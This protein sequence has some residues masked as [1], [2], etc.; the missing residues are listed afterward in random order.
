MSDGR[1]LFKVIT[2]AVVRSQR[3]LIG[4]LKPSSKDTS[5]GRQI[6]SD[7]WFRELFGFQ[8]SSCARDPARV[9][10]KFNFD[11]KTGDL[12][13]LSNDQTFNAGFFSTPSLTE[14]REAAR[15]I[16]LLRANGKARA[17]LNGRDKLQIRHVATKDVFELHAQKEFEGATF[18]AASQFNCLE[19]PGPSVVPED[20]INDYVYDGTQGPACALAAP[21]GTVV[22]N[23]FAPTN[24][25]VGQTEENQVRKQQISRTACFVFV[26]SNKCRC[27]FVLDQQS[28]GLANFSSAPRQFHR[29]G[30]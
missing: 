30:D 29:T 18:M 26:L 22:R 24:G 27:L 20:G 25:S 16:G 6:N 28:G 15:K 5:K 19:F 7:D 1:T 14:L 2:K 21:A 11:R 10:S 9:R 12:R 13:S 17:T 3:R 8:E 4:M 23:Y